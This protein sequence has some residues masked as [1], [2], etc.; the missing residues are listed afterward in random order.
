MERILHAQINNLC[1]A[2]DSINLDS[3]AYAAGARFDACLEGTRTDLLAEIVD[4]ICSAEPNCPCVL[5]L[6]GPMLS[7]LT[8]AAF[9]KGIQK[10]GI[11]STIKHF[12]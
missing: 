9:I 1:W 8:A 4:W 5:W 12:V 6:H 7:G 11:G 3:I 10:G 2:G